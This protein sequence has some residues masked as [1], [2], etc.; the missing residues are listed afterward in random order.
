MASERADI[1]IVGGGVIGVACAW[2]LARRGA[3]PLVIEG[4]AVAHAAS[5]KAAG[6]LSPLM[7]PADRETAALAP[8]TERGAALH[9]TLAELLDGPGTYDYAP[10][11]SC[12]LARDADEAAA[13]RED[14]ETVGGEWIESDALAE[15]CAWLDRPAAG[16]GLL[17]RSAQLDP[18]KF[19]LRLMESAKGMG[20]SLRTGRAAG[21]LGGPDYVSGVELE[22]GDA[23]SADAVVLALGPWTH[24]AAAWLDLPLPVRPLKGEIVHLEPAAEPP[25][26]G[27][28]DFDGQ[29]AVTKP[30]GVVYAGTT[31]E[32]AGFD[33]APTPAAR[34]RI[35][36]D[37]ARRTSRLEGARVVDQ[38]ACLRPLSADGLPLIGAAPGRRGAWVAAGHGR[39]GILL[40][41]ATGEAIAELMLD[42]RATLD[43]AP[44]DPA[45]FGARG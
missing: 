24:R 31:A 16:G 12:A 18:A 33:D 30:T 29:Y 28:S 8:L 5:G 20:A 4:A 26:G 19:T 17:L 43:L 7:P 44:F 14:A 23:V 9:A 22:G 6:L 36:A 3:R 37:V 45:R 32:E 21:L 11:E 2:H 35:L 10:Y 34:A 25:P 15:R 42:G 41:L 27:F 13:L 38:T 39:K 1:A 40:A